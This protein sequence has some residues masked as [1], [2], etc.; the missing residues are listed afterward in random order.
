MSKRTYVCIE[1]RATKRAEAAYGVNTDNRCPQCQKAM[2][3]LPWE[4][5]IPKVNNDIEWEKLRI[6]LFKIESAWRP[7]QRALS[8]EKLDK[9]D[10]QIEQI[11][12]QRDSEK[13]EEKLKKLLWQKREIERKYTEQKNRGD[14]E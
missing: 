14:L 5:R 4:W 12:K 3:E 10:K 8:K 9:I 2:I 6:M 13:K 1:C 11:S 7:R